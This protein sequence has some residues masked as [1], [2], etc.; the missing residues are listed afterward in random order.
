MK[1]QQSAIEKLCNIYPDN[2]SQS[3]NFKDISQAQ[4]V[5]YRMEVNK[6]ADEWDATPD[7]IDQ[8]IQ[9]FV[10]QNHNGDE[11]MF[12][13][14]TSLSEKVAT[15]LQQEVSSLKYNNVKH[16]YIRYGVLS[17]GFILH[18]G[19]T[20][21]DKT[22][23]VRAAYVTPNGVTDDDSDNWLSSIVIER[24]LYDYD[25][26]VATCYR[27]EKHKNVESAHEWVVKR[28]N[29]YNHIPLLFNDFSA[30][31]FLKPIS[32]TNDS[33]DVPIRKL[34][35]KRI[36]AT[37]KRQY[38]RQ[39]NQEI[40][41]ENFNR[42]TDIELIRP[43]RAQ[44]VIYDIKKGEYISLIPFNGGYT[45]PRPGCIE[46]DAGTGGQ[47]ISDSEVQQRSSKG[48]YTSPNTL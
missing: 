35:T 46:L 39:Y 24:N 1:S 12:S 32:E 16:N 36:P 13:E 47:W 29:Q 43:N 20:P 27:Q 37:I 25:D 23:I 34:E 8:L 14:Q 19:G 17:G 42:F 3:I 15:V 28:I 31:L 11:N 21:P 44:S 7:K 45:M 40:T 5:L 2:F 41:G 4:S 22:S 10:N 33:V 9:Q 6:M 48:R 18:I 26:A 38:K 30:G